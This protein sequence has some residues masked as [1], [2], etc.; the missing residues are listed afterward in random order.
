MKI[1]TQN[2]LTYT[3]TSAECSVAAPFNSFFRTKFLPGFGL[4]QD[5]GVRANNPLAIALK[6]S[7]KIWPSAKKNDLLLSIG[8]G[9]STSGCYSV[10]DASNVFC[11][12]SIPR[13]IRATLSSPC[14]DGEQGFVEALNYLP[15]DTK[16]DIFRLNQVI[17]GPLPRLDDVEKIS[18]MLDLSY[19]VPDHLIRTIL[20]SAFFFFELDDEPV[21]RHDDF[22]CQGSILCSRGDT[23]IILKQIFLEM[24]NAHFQTARGQNLG[25][26]HGNDG[27]SLCGYYRKT[28]RF[29]VT[30]VDEMTSIEIANTRFSHKIGGF[31]KSAQELL[32]EQQSY[33]HFGRA[34][35]KVAQWPPSRVCYC[36][37]ATKRRIQFLEPS[38]DQK[39]RK[40]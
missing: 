9:V 30:N 18:S 5:G 11:D 4:L 35:H 34:D 13:L 2:E 26:I 23:N 17:D 36:S 28:V 38:L 31:P 8:T 27:C 6:E 29:S 1:C 7:N 37:R 24:P 16:S 39:R 21:K 15:S 20:A 12:G 22:L 40:V 3:P 33:A 25:G 19:S 10:P 32:T 14:M